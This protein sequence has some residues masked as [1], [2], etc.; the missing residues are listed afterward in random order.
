[1]SCANVPPV[2]T[3]RTVVARR[4]ALGQ[5]DLQRAG[6]AVRV[7]GR[8]GCGAGGRERAQPLGQRVDRVDASFV[9]EAVAQRFVA[10]RR[11]GDV[12]AQRAHVEAGA[13]DDQRA[14]AA[15]VDRVDRGQRVA[16]EARR[17]NSARAGSRKP[18]RWCGTRAWSA[19][20]GAAVP[21]GM[22]R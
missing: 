14:F 22:P 2:V 20:L 9:R 5:G 12:A 1:M 17:P 3:L 6:D 11:E 8:D 13:A 21:T 10:H 18:T 16:H 19:A 15:G 7:A 4:V